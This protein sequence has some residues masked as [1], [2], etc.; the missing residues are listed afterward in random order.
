MKKTLLFFAIMFFANCLQS[1]TSE[2]DATEI[3]NPVKLELKGLN[4]F[5]R[6]FVLE[7]YNNTYQSGSYDTE[8]E[9]EILI[10][11]AY[12]SVGIDVAPAFNNPIT[13]SSIND[14]LEN[15][16]DEFS[17]QQY[18][19]IKELTMLENPTIEDIISLK[20]KA[21]QLKETE[22]D[23][24]LFIFNAIES[25]ATGFENGLLNTPQTRGHAL[26]C[27]LA[28]GA[29]GACAGF[30]AGCMGG[31]VAAYLVSWSVSAVLSTY[32]C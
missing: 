12:N 7:M 19:I 11:C 13:R 20:K 29:V 10:K 31:P 16:R 28:T 23:K 26:G 24:I 14:C 22:Q 8:K 3:P 27:N 6:N 21:Y 30:L 4:D 18:A 15:Y 25:V 2:N 9:K 1:C 17:E 32:A 5:S